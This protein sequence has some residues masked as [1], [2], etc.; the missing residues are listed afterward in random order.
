MSCKI[1]LS[2]RTITRETRV[3]FTEM[4]S[5]AMTITARPWTLIH[6]CTHTLCGGIKR[7]ILQA[8]A[9]L[10]IACIKESV[11]TALFKTHLSAFHCS[12]V[13]SQ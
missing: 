8:F 4:E 7:D 6:T 1:R 12:D 9:S 2:F 3:L 11:A 13:P 10:H 5:S